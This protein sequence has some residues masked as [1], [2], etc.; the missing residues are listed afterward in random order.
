MLQPPPG[1]PRVGLRVRLKDPSAMKI[2]DPLRSHLSCLLRNW[3]PGTYEIANF[4]HQGGEHL[5]T[6]HKEGVLAE[7]KWDKSRGK[8][9]AWWKDKA[10]LIAWKYL[11]AV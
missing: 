6:L 9:P 5:V 3:G 1:S 2:S 4:V 11:E 10:E 7:S 8:K